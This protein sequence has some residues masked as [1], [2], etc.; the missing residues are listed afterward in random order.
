MPQTDCLLPDSKPN[1]PPRRKRKSVSRSPSLSPTKTRRGRIAPSPPTS[2]RRGQPKPEVVAAVPLEPKPKPESDHALQFDKIR[3]DTPNDDSASSDDEP[4][5]PDPRTKST[6][7]PCP[8]YGGSFLA[9]WDDLVAE[10]YERVLKY[11]PTAVQREQVDTPKSHKDHVQF[12]RDRFSDQVLFRNMAQRADA[13]ERFCLKH[14]RRAAELEAGAK[15][16]PGPH[17]FDPDALHMRVAALYPTLESIINS[18][19]PPDAPENHFYRDM[20]DEYERL[21]GPG[22]RNRT[23]LQRRLQRAR[24]GYYGQRGQRVLS[25]ALFAAYVHDPE[26][27]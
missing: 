8:F 15:D 11:F 2:R 25:S 7:C 14:R 9:T 27:A 16:W 18:S 10:I 26:N 20:C 12:I 4:S 5:E 22:F 21:G 17:E 13:Q 23:N 3:R 19:I 6:E 1:S 24:P